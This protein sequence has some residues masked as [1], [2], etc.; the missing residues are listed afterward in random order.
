MA[1]D[2]IL[3]VVPEETNEQGIL[4]NK[5][6]CVNCGAELQDG[7][8]FCPKCGHKVGEAVS[9]KPSG[10]LKFNGKMTKNI[11]VVAIVVV[12]LIIVS[13][14]ALGTQAKSITLNTDNVAVKVGE[15]AS[16]SFTIDPENTKNKNVTW[17]TSNESIAT[18]NNGLIVGVN[19]GDCTI[20]V[21]TKNGKKDS[22]TVV[23][24]PAGPDLQAIYNQCCS[25]TFAVLAS[26]GSYLYV[27]TN[28]NDI[29]DYTDYDAYAA[30]IA[31]NEE[32]GLPESVLNRMN[33]TRSLD[34]VQSYSTDDLDITWTYHPDN[35]LQV[36]YSLK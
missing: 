23:V 24:E 16:L 34:G 14:W 31:I 25:S 20:T 8:L 30:I 26:D 10:T 19:E 6:F 3:A 33:Q 9:S 35:G 7:Q 5:L 36:N 13:F 29:D 12:A 21:T 17:A 1:E 27:D 4:P 18:V 2:N 15:T 28:P 22:C 11:A 32:L